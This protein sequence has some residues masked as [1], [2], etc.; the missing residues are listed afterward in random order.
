MIHEQI[1]I[2]DP[3]IQWNTW[4]K[5]FFMDFIPVGSISS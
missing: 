4:R 5:R 1:S 3:I 2:A